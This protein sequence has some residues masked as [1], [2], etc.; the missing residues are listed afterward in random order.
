MDNRE[1]QFIPLENIPEKPTKNEIKEMDQFGKRLDEIEKKREL[2]D[3]KVTR[4][5]ISINDS[6]KRIE[7][8]TTFMMFVA[9]AILISFSLAF[10]TLSF[11]YYKRNEDNLN[12][13][14]SRIE[15]LEE[16]KFEN[17]INSY[18]IQRSNE[19]KLI[20]DVIQQH[21]TDN[22]V[23]RNCLKNKRY[24]QYEECAE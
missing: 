15:S 6:E 22:E 5:G 7:K 10:V 21:Q 13:L 12:K 4:I 24:W 20:T 11:E 16:K 19:L 1:E 23:F 18:D 8:T 9:G 17:V 2:I 3:E 14:T